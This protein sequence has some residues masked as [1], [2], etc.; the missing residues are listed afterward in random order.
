MLL[1]DVAERLLEWGRT[2]QRCHRN[3]IGLMDI[4][5]QRLMSQGTQWVVSAEFPD[6]AKQSLIRLL[7]STLS[8]PKFSPV[9]TMHVTS[10]PTVRPVTL[11]IQSTRSYGRIV[12]TS[13]DQPSV[14][15]EGRLPWSAGPPRIKDGARLS[16]PGE[17]APEDLGMLATDTETRRAGGRES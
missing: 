5:P 4:F 7:H 1:E 17:T 11:A 16:P 2:K 3:R 14:H 8:F 15:L 10:V 12:R 6:L 9:D 13:G